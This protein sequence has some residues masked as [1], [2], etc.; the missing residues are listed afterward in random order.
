MTLREWMN[1]NA[2]MHRH[3]TRYLGHRVLKAPFDW[4]VIGD[5][6][7]DTNPQIIIEVG[8]GEGGFTLWMA[9]LLDAMN[10]E[11]EILSIDIKDSASGIDHKRIKWI[12]G[13]ALANRTL[14]KVEELSKSRR[15]IVIEDSDHKYATTKGILDAYAKFVDVDCYLIVEDTIVDFL[16]LPPFPGP[17]K[18]VIEFSEA[19]RDA[20]VIDRTREKY[21]VTHNPMGHLLRI[22]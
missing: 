19:H 16:N 8:S 20:F 6:I 3:N 13:D 17:L 15:G 1:F 10:S 22:A 9:H 5:I 18:A 12:V 11:A 14:Q 7:Q 4:I 2:T 21:I